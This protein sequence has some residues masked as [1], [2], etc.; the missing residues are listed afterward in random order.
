M[1]LAISIN[2]SP[3]MSRCSWTRILHFLK[4]LVRQFDVSTDKVKVGIVSYAINAKVENGFNSLNPTFLNVEEIQR[5]ISNV[6]W[7][8]G[9]SRMDKA[10]ETVDRKLF[11]TKEGMR[12]KSLKVY[13]PLSLQSSLIY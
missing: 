3:N 12:S 11:N 8:T 6:F 5:I 13:A 2:A 1:D 4:T 10:L 7:K 9:K